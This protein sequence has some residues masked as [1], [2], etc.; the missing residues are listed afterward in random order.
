MRT[1]SKETLD[2]LVNLRHELHRHAE[3]SSREE[4]TAQIMMQWF[5]QCKPDHT[6]D[7]LGG[8]GLAFVFEGEKPGKTVLL[9]CELD[10]LPIPEENTFEYKI[11]RAHV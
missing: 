2:S 7:G 9:R 3:L 4:K 8:F 1:L 11:G 5:S 6:L 10:A